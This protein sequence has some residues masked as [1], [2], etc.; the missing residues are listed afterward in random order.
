MSVATHYPHRCR[1]PWVSHCSPPPVPLSER[2]S[3]CEEEMKE[4]TREGEGKEKK[5]GF[6]NMFMLTQQPHRTNLDQ[7]RLRTL[8]DLIL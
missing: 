7:N 5:G 2:H 3:R 4:E 8:S 1:G 6:T